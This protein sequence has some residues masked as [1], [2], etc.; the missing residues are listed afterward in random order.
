MNVL[1][2]WLLLFKATWRRSVG[3]LLCLVAGLVL[4]PGSWTTEQLAIKTGYWDRVVARVSDSVFWKRALIIIVLYAL[5]QE[6]I[7]LLAYY[8]SVWARSRIRKE[9]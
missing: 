6:I 4:V 1:R 2:R 9:R 5:A 7:G 8:F 3:I